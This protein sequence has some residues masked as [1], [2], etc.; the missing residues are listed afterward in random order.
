MHAT[1][2]PEKYAPRCPRQVVQ[3]KPIPSPAAELSLTLCTKGETGPI[4]QGVEVVG[5]QQP[6]EVER[7]RAE[8]FPVCPSTE[9]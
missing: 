4:S 1:A 5:P 3:A 2:P 7:K 9:V 6:N 8:E